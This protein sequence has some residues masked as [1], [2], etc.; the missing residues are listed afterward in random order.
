M[1]SVVDRMVGVERP[2]RKGYS[3]GGERVPA[4][5]VIDPT[6]ELGTAIQRAMMKA[7]DNMARRRGFATAPARG[8]GA[9]SPGGARLMGYGELTGKFIGEG[10]S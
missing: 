3:L 4:R 6:P 8:L 2:R 9:L 1:G 10:T 7:I 5:R